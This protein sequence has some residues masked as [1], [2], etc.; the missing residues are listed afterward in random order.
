M[1]VKARQARVPARP[2]PA[3]APT[4][5]RV[6]WLSRSASRRMD[7]LTLPAKCGSSPASPSGRQGGCPNFQGRCRVVE[8]RGA[9]FDGPTQPPTRENT[10][11]RKSPQ[12]SPELGE[13]NVRM[14]E[15][16]VKRREKGRSKN[17]LAISIPTVKNRHPSAYGA[18]VP[19]LH[20]LRIDCRCLR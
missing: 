9:D 10:A 5:E 7:D 12:F 15:V 19:G 18:H 17:A 2:V 1:I 16:M 6:D 3:D 13:R 11:M 20:R 14:V 4:A 8:Q